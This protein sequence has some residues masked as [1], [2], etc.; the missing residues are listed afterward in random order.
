MRRTLADFAAMTGLACFLAADPL[1]AA[2]R[3]PDDACAYW[4]A[5]TPSEWR[6][7]LE[8]A[9]ARWDAVTVTFGDIQSWRAERA[10]TEPEYAQTVSDVYIRVTLKGHGYVKAHG[11]ITDEEAYQ[12][13]LVWRPEHAEAVRFDE[14]G[15]A[16]NAEGKLRAALDQQIPIRSRYEVLRD[17][18]TIVYWRCNH[19][20]EASEV[21]R[22]AGAMMDKDRSR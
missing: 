17:G 15:N 6:G 19:A 16:L 10:K 18:L 22:A 13:L 9:R 3:P 12:Y 14:A 11:P 20:P 1:G 21:S 8:D 2:T 5:R 4:L 7:A